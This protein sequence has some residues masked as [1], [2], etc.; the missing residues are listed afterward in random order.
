MQYLHQD[1]SDVHVAWSNQR[2]AAFSHKHVAGPWY[3]GSAGPQRPD[4]F[5]HMKLLLWLSA[6]WVVVAQAYTA[7]WLGGGWCVSNRDGHL[8]GIIPT[9]YQVVCER[10]ASTSADCMC[11][12]RLSIQFR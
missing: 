7:G 11:S 8:T 9:A 1:Q 12:C 6:V 3:T 5:A 4:S 10:L 2:R